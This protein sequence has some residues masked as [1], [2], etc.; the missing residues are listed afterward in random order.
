MSL[1]DLV[2]EKLT[3]AYVS[4]PLLLAASQ[5]QAA[6]G[7]H[8]NFNNYESVLIPLAGGMIGASFLNGIRQQRKG[9]RGEAIFDYAV[10][11][12]VTAAVAAYVLLFK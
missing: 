4:L 6:N 7:G 3:T 11:G 10:G 8:D 1:T 12:M 5:V 9:N 2:T